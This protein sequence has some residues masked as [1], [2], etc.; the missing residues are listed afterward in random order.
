MLALASAAAV[1]AAA[2]NAMGAQDRLAA[3]RTV[4]YSA[5]GYRQMVEQ[6]EHPHGP[7][8]MDAGRVHEVRD[9]PGR[10]V[11]IEQSD[12]AYGALNWWL[13]QTE[14]IDTTLIVDRDR[15]G[16]VGASGIHPGGSSYFDL[17]RDA[18]IFEPE[19][20]LLNAVRARD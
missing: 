9:I 8:S 17:N 20:L 19:L 10:R 6:S 1:L 18:E 13:T 7:Y 16:V 2:L 3:V 12:A 11:R 4:A 5:V 14:P 15:I